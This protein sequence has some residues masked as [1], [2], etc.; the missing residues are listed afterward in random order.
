M[1][2]NAKKMPCIGNGEKSAMRHSLGGNI[3]S[4]AKEEDNLSS[5]KHINRLFGGTFRMLRNIWMAFHFLDKVY[6]KN[7]NY[8][9]QTETGICRSNMVPAQEKACV[10]IRKDTENCN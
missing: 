2:F 10:E 7:Y 3:I 1:E 9:D 5:E 8:N 6:E 4:V